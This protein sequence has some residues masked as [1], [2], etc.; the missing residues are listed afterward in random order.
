MRLLTR[1]IR[2]PDD[3]EP[4][5]NDPLSVPPSTVGPDQLVE[6]GDPHGV[7]LVGE[8]TPAWTPPSIIPSPWSGWPADWWTPLWGSRQLSSLADTAWM[9][10][11]L[12]A[13]LLATMPPYLVNAAPSLPADW[14][15]N[16]D[17]DIYSSWEEFAKQL[18][19]DYQLGEAFV[20]V[21]A[22]YATNWPARFHVV[23]P[24]A[25]DVE[26]GGDGLRRYRI[27]RELI[28]SRDLLH[29]RYQS[30]VDDA[31]GHGPLEVGQARLVAARVLMS[32][33]TTLAAGGGI[34]SSVLEHPEELD[35]AQASLL[36]AQW[37]Q[38]RMSKL[39]EPAVLSCGVTWKAS[40]LNPEEMALV[41]I[42]DLTDRRIA[43]LLGVPPFLVGIPTG[44][45]SMTYAN[46][47]S[48]FLHHWR[49]SLRPKAQTVMAALSEW[50]VP[51]GTR[52]EVNRDAYIEP[53]PFVRAQTVEILN[54]IRDDDGRPAMTVDEIRGAERFDDSTP[55][56]LAS[57][58]LK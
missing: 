41:P 47:T 23:P 56:D 45:D 24:W 40:Q 16:P 32:Y 51:R 21:T 38:A 17:P 30:S 57:G 7:T 48:L 15:R 52:I 54:R 18:F 25:V 28:D 26:L 29:I 9:C 10:I 8:P 58:V 13:S 1:A 19:W 12:N 4:N 34:P 20:I 6:P 50:L 5:A 11:D 49:S 35:A 39:G 42:V 37:V 36:Q 43:S 55:T 3:V 22:R 31:H 46:V 2:P 44:G 33:V 14:L 27:G 53:E